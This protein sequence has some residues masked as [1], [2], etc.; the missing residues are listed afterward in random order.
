MF[1]R[2]LFIFQ[3]AEREIPGGGAQ[4]EAERFE[5]LAPADYFSDVMLKN[6]E[7]SL[8]RVSGIKINNIAKL[9]F[10]ARGTSK[11]K[12]NFEK[13]GK[14]HDA[15]FDVARDAATLNYKL[16]ATIYDLAE[17][18]VIFEKDRGDLNY[19]SVQH[20]LSYALHQAFVAN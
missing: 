17:D 1:L 20:A 19:G 3:H 12:I 2:K 10:T 7:E 4:S 8:G 16:S 9:S 14:P 11:I 5:G 6:L 18:I 13:D 15:F